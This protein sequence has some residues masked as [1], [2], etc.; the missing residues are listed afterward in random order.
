MNKCM[1]DIEKIR[2]EILL[3]DKKIWGITSLSKKVGKTFISELL[4]EK[5]SEIGKN[6]L[7]ITIGEED[8]SKLDKA[9]QFVEKGEIIPEKYWCIKN[10]EST[11]AIIFDDKFEKLLSLYKK[12]YD[13]IIIDMPSFEES[14]FSK[15]LCKVCDENIV[16]VSKNNEDGF[17]SGEKIRHL[18]QMGISI[19]GIVLNEYSNKKAIFRI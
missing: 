17:K 6:V 14:I 15:K 4:V 10:V 13:Y 7:Y 19:A 2:E 3:S 5:I 16:V 11:A 8:N 1:I 9:I 12:V 18:Q